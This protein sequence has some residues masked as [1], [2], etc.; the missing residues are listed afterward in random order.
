[1]IVGAWVRDA[2]S[3]M[4]ECASRFVSRGTSRTRPS[5]SPTP[6]EGWKG[7]CLSR[8]RSSSRFIHCPPSGP[9]TPTPSLS[10]RVGV[11]SSRRRRHLDA[12]A[13]FHI[14]TTV[15]AS[16]RVFTGDGRSRRAI[17]VQ[18]RYDRV[19]YLRLDLSADEFDHKL[20][21]ALETLGRVDIS[22]GGRISITPRSS[23]VSFL[24]TRVSINGEIPARPTA[25]AARSPHRTRSPRRWSAGRRPRLLHC[26]HR[27][28][29]DL[30]PAP[31]TSRHREGD[32]QLRAGRPQGRCRL[33]EAQPLQ[34]RAT[35]YEPPDDAAARG[36][37]RIDST[38]PACSAVPPPASAP[39]RQE[40][41]SPPASATGPAPPS[42]VAH[43]GPR[44]PPRRQ[45]AGAA[46]ADGATGPSGT[47]APPAAAAPARPPAASAPIGIMRGRRGKSCQMLAIP[48]VPCRP[49]PGPASPASASPA[50]SVGLNSGE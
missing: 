40:S 30:R 20:G 49:W 38:R 22:D 31:A 48:A 7:R 23:L 46:S 41:P 34:R 17:H 10:H 11:S 5:T 45:V 21:D 35:A 42:A 1:M 3:W 18:R 8:P 9:N 36:T 39:P 27:Q 14:P 29:I 19:N 16:V 6:G 24:S 2:V 43:D 33:Q 12:P 25:P 13:N 50:R 32:L 15:P 26:A 37:F 44:H 47:P 28:A 4:Y